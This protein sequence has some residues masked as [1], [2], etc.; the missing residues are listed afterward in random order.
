MIAAM[1]RQMGIEDI[2]ELHADDTVDALSEALYK[3]RE[4]DL[5]ILSGGVSVGKYDKVP[6]ALCDAGVEI[7]FHKITQKPGKPLLFGKKGLRLFFGL[8]G[9]PLACHLGFHRYIAAA[10]RKMMGKDPISLLD[11]GRLTKPANNNGTRT[12]F[13]QCHT[14]RGDDGCWEITVLKGKG[15]A[16]IFAACRAN[17]YVRFDPE[18]GEVKA[19]AEVP[20]TW[21]GDSR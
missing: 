10:I 7:V 9:N 5:T 12:R 19:G 16:D 13:A 1:V 11:V 14:V 8:P 3:A 21:V 15:S 18:A 6:A 17:S 4:A 20:F 2:Q